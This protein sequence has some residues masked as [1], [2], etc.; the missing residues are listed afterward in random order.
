[1]RSCARPA[2]QV[3]DTAAINKKKGGFRP[4]R[5]ATPDAMAVVM[6][7]IQIM[8]SLKHDHVPTLFEVIDDPI[9]KK[10]FLVMELLQVRRMRPRAVCGRKPA[11]ATA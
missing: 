8:L 7:E 9:A 5:D 11:P 4:G 10:I 1:M 3:I 2:V 6:N